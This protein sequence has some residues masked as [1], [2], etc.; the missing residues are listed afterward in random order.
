[1]NE[2]SS[3]LGRLLDEATAHYQPQPDVARFERMLVVQH[4]RRAGIVMRSLRDSYACLSA[5]HKQ[6]SS[7][8]SVWTALERRLRLW[9]AAAERLLA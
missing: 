1:M 7:S 9:C 5:M 4:R 8:N 2:H 6:P 3:H